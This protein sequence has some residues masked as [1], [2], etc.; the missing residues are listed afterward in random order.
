MVARSGRHNPWSQKSSIE[1]KGK[2]SRRAR[3]ARRPPRPG[4]PPTAFGPAELDSPDRFHRLSF[5]S[6]S[7]HWHF[8]ALASVFIL[9]S[10][11]TADCVFS[12]PFN[13]RSALT[14]RS[15]SI[16]MADNN[17]SQ[18]VARVTKPVSEALL[19]E[20]VRSTPDETPVPYVD[21]RPHGRWLQS[22]PKRLVRS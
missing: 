21:C 13:P 19:N 9:P 3:D 6:C 5:D 17:G 20:K 12:F 15:R 2:K 11:S 8:S 4:F 14:L 10:P 7:S 22:N 16:T 1:E 18:P